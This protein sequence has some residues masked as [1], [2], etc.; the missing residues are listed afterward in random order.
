MKQPRLPL[1]PTSY[2]AGADA[3][4][5]RMTPEGRQRT[6]EFWEARKSPNSTASAK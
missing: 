1:Q 2:Q 3:L 4:L 6:R 5:K